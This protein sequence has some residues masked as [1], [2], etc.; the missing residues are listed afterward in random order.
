M[1][2]LVQRVA[3]A[4][5]RVAGERVSRIG[6]G[7][8]I[9]LG[10]G[11]AD[12]KEEVTRLA[13]KIARARIFPDERGLMNRD[14]EAFGGAVLIVSQFTLFADL[15]RGNR[16]GFSRAAAPERAKA[17]YHEFIAEFEALG[18]EVASGHFGA[19]MEVELVNMGPVTLWYDTD[20]L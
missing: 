18:F 6:P 8:L 14:L 12:G 3:R 1:R 16:P 13:K 2:A 20:E 17:L 7:L 11:P 4:E 5:I 9:L 10:V 19:E 15:K